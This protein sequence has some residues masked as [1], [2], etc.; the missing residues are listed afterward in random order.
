M[1]YE[2]KK[3]DLIVF[4]GEYFI[5]FEGGKYE[6]DNK[7]EIAILDKAIDVSQVKEKSK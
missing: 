4:T 5:K 6:T 2:S 7:E 3:E 1:K